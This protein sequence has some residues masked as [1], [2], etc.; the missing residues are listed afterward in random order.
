M[1]VMTCRVG[2]SVRIGEDIRMAVQGRVGPRVAVDLRVAPKNQV[3]LEGACLEPA[4][5]PCGSHSHLLSLGGMRRFQVGKFE[6]G[7][8]LPSDTVSDA[9]PCADF[10]HI[11]VTGPGPLRVGYQQD[12]ADVPWV[13]CLPPAIAGIVH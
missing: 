1:L 7:I 9:S 13:Y 2:S 8:W 3:F 10:I 6:V 4:V 11:G 5:L 12:G